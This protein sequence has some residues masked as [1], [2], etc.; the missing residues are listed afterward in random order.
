[1]LGVGWALVTPLVMM[2]AFS[3]VFNRVTKVDTGGA[4]YQLFSYLGLVP[5][6]F[7]SAS[8][9]GASSS[10]IGNFAL[11]N[12]VHC[13]RE[14]F[15][16][17]AVG[18]ALFD[19]VLSLVALAALFALNGVAPQP[20]SYWVPVLLLIIA[21]QTLA[22]A[23]LAGVLTVFIRDLRYALPLLLQVGIFVTPVGYP[24]EAIPDTWRMPYT[25]LNPIAAAIDGLRR[26]V[27]Y[28]GTPDVGYT[29]AAAGG[30]VMLFII[31]LLV[32]KKMEPGIADVA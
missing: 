2:V 5:W 12:K 16:F 9:S 26:T 30:A 1:M 13:P 14:L 18:V 7:F 6:T 27:L 3:L 31:S 8:M 29:A 19:A 22:L 17:S 10:L 23:L 25:V 32:F 4:P 28:G 15:P 11:V 24:F 20:T 21:F